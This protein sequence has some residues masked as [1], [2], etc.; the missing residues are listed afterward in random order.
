[1]GLGMDLAQVLTQPDFSER[2]RLHADLMVR[3]LRDCPAPML[4]LT[5]LP[6]NAGDRLIWAGTRRLLEDFWIP[7]GE[8]SVPDARDGAGGGGTLVVPGSGAWVRQWHEWLPDLV[9]AAAER[10]ERVVVLPSQY[11]PT[12]PIVRRALS[13]PNVFAFARETTSYRAI[14]DVGRAVLAFDP[15]LYAWSFDLSAERT[16][17]WIH[18]PTLISLRTDSGS[19]LHESGLRIDPSRN[20]DISEEARDLEDFVQR[21]RRSRRVVTDRLHVVVAGIMSGIPVDYVDPYRQKI[22]EYVHF[23]FGREAEGLVVKRSPEW[24]AE[25][26]FALD[27]VH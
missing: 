1:M 10:F 6:G 19:R 26:G 20:T 23:T 13:H 16:A 15:A 18:E 11:D 25:W 17:D 7:F 5:D 3:F 2:R 9:D 21:I 14:K 24:L 4:L 8:V 22:S 12:I 27:G